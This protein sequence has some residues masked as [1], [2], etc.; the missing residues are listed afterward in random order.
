MPLT[1]VRLADAP[2]VL[3]PALRDLADMDPVGVDVERADWD[4]YF[5]R[6]ALIQVGGA[7]RVVLVDPITLDDLT[8]LA[9]YLGERRVVLHAMDNDLGP[10]AAA[11]VPVP[12]VEDTAIAAGILGLPTGLEALLRDLL[13]VE[14]TGDKSAMQRA[15]WEARPLSPDMLDYAAGDVADLPELWSVIEERLH[16]AGRWDWYRQEVAAVL[17]LP[18]AEERRDWMKVKGAGRL[19]PQARAR[20]R[21]LWTEREAVAQRTDTAPSRVAPDKALLAMATDPPRDRGELMRRGVRRQAA[22][23]FGEGLLD[24]VRSGADAAPE[25]SLRRGRSHTEADREL[26]DELRRLR[27]A[28]AE[29]VGIDAGI[30]C[31]SRTLMAGVVA[32]P[33]DPEELRDALGLRPWQWELLGERFWAA[34]VAARAEEV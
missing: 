27:T 11:G 9:D 28:A 21:A 22:R 29:E 2:D 8:P 4:R 30:V 10:M 17:A 13:E 26:V 1:S 16:A 12:A 18:P 3:T 5:R 25:R 15:D 34:V 6:A 33:Q 20:L 24:A 23:D 31:P 32:D 7:G 14:L 19:D